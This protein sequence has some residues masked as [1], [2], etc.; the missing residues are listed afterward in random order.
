MSVRT[1]YFRV[2]RGPLAIIA[3]CLSLVT[4]FGNETLAES[5]SW[6][7]QPG[8]G[9]GEIVAIGPGDVRANHAWSSGPG[10]T[11]ILK[12]TYADSIVEHRFDGFG[13]LVFGETPDHRFEARYSSLGHLT[14]VANTGTPDLGL[15]SDP[16]GQPVEVSVGATLLKRIKYDYLGRVQSIDTPA[17]KLVYR[18]DTAGNRVI[19]ILPNGVRS[20]W[21]YDA[22]DRLV[23]L[24]HIDAEN[25]VLARFEYLYRPDHLISQIT[26]YTQHKGESV[27]HFGYDVMHRL[28]SVE[29]TNGSFERFRYDEASNLVAWTREGGIETAFQS[30]VAGQLSH[31]SAGEVE[32]DARG[33]LRRV[34]TR[35]GGASFGYNDAGLVARINDDTGLSYDALGQLVRHGETDQTVFLPDPLALSWQPLWQRGPDGVER[36]WIW[37]G[38]APLIEIADGRV[39]YRLEDHLGSPRVVLDQAGTPMRWPGYSAF[40]VPTG[41]GR[42]EPGFAGHF[43][44]PEGEVYLVGPRAYH[45]ESARFLQPDPIKRA[46]GRSRFSHSLYAYAAGDPVNFVDRDGR[47]ASPAH[48]RSGGQVS[49]G[50]KTKMQP[51]SDPE[52]VR[53]AYENARLQARR[54]LKA[55]NK[56]LT[57]E[58]LSIETW[59]VVDAWRQ[60]QIYAEKIGLGFN[61]EIADPNVYFKKTKTNASF[62]HHRFRDNKYYQQFKNAEPLSPHDWQDLDRYAY[63][64]GAVVTGMEFGLK[65]NSFSRKVAEATMP[66]HLTESYWAVAHEFGKHGLLSP[67][68]ALLKQSWFKDTGLTKQETAALWLPLSQNA[69]FYSS[70]ARKDGR[71]EK[72][73]IKAQG[74]DFT[75]IKPAGIGAAP[76][77]RTKVIMPDRLFAVPL[78][79][80]PRQGPSKNRPHGPMSHSIGDRAKELADVAMAAIDLT[81]AARSNYDLDMG[82]MD[83]AGPMGVASPGR[84][85]LAEDLASSGFGVPSPVGGV[86]LSGEHI[87]R[88]DLADITGVAL[89]ERTGKIVLV[90]KEE[91]RALPGLPLHVVSQIFMATYAHGA[92][93]VTIDPDPADPTGPVMHVIHS[94][95]SAS[96]YTGWVLEMADKWL[97]YYHLSRNA[98]TREPVTTQV[99]GYGEILQ[100]VFFG[101]T[102]DTQSNWERFWLVPVARSRAGDKAGG[103]EATAFDV[104]LMVKTQKMIWTDGK[105]VDDIAGQSSKGARAFATWFTNNYSAIAEEV[106][107]LPPAETGITEPVAIFRELERIA[108]ISVIAEHLRD[109]GVP[110]PLW[111]QHVTAPDIPFSPVTPALTVNKTSEDFPG[112]V[113]RIYGGATLQSD[114]STR[115]AIAPNGDVAGNAALLEAS[116]LEGDF[117]ELSDA[118]PGIEDLVRTPGQPAV[119]QGNL[120]DGLSAMVLPGAGSK[121]FGA[122]RLSHRDIAISFGRGEVL[123]LRRHYNSFFRIEGVLGAGWTF[124][125]P[126]LA[127]TMRSLPVKE[128]EGHQ[129]LLVPNLTSDLGSYSGAFNRTEMV[130]ALGAELLVADGL[131][132]VLGMAQGEDP[133]QGQTVWRLYFRGGAVWHFDQSGRLT[134]TESRGV[135]RQVHYDDGGRLKALVGVLGETPMATLEIEYDDLGRV[136]AVTGAVREGIGERQPDRVSYSYSGSGALEC[137]S[138]GGGKCRYIY[139]TS[140]DG[141]ITAVT[142]AGRR[143]DFAYAGNGA[144]VVDGQIAPAT[145]FDDSMRPIAQRAG[146]GE[147]R[148]TYSNAGGVTVAMSKNGAPLARLTS[149]PGVIKVDWSGG[150]EA[151]LEAEDHSTTVLSTG[152]VPFGQLKWRTD[153]TIASATLGNTQLTPLFDGG[154]IQSGVMVSAPTDGGSTDQWTRETWDLLGR[155]SEVTDSSGR[156]EVY[157][158]DEEGRLHTVGLLDEDGRVVGH[159]FGYD[160]AGRLGEI[161][162]S[163]DKTTIGRDES[164]D[165]ISLVNQRDGFTYSVQ[166]S[167]NSVKVVDY[168]GGLTLWSRDPE[169]P[170]AVEVVLPNGMTV[171]HDGSVGEG[172]SQELVFAGRQIRVQQST[173][174]NG[175]ETY[176]WSEIRR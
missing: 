34:P 135:R 174:D 101:Q 7:W 115:I 15:T 29:E 156:K 126:R 145:R 41:V 168:D 80:S 21:R 22:E 36:L 37:D 92:P 105:L 1:K 47:Q 94:P 9:E 167:D 166:A 140:R 71:K 86:Y 176:V 147:I 35:N 163:W 10:G 5:L 114:A 62:P 76:P 113:A 45:P 107:L 96:T 109:R 169:R 52:K 20:E 155:I 118:L 40:G 102:G 72:A 6:S 77:V 3:A 4:G 16:F 142:E 24:A 175:G 144:L 162:S 161:N 128:K 139:E 133:A 127:F 98:E 59:L 141:Q 104:T 17:G 23:S 91:H 112:V 131:P 39:V 99:A 116:S 78:P 48:A 68:Q 124:D 67:K 57:A 51:R 11:P 85:A 50:Y 14:R 108:T 43:W 75:N 31:H 38:F 123:E 129:R 143:T 61:D 19:R 95:D 160:S 87:A 157:S 42:M 66:I 150:A 138:V 159:Q 90:G 152:N 13:N 79:F 33:H 164:G 88:V 93:W 103:I 2:G 70:Q 100:K 110:L 173:M 56:P 28:V 117:G 151:T 122:N 53:V 26:E 12:V 170:E 32:T 172:T 27:R 69:G 149:E 89:D 49:G 30:G 154:A 136:A 54:N 134:M 25:F 44:E 165:V 83:G 119:A 132:W 73:L 84:K 82:R 74:N 81:R 65:P 171:L 130:E 46:P 55:Q 8:E 60:N 18:H 97:K 64:R 106:V 120:D 63:R 137:V 158:Y 146:G 148:W 121:A 58:A 153:G 111:M 125:L